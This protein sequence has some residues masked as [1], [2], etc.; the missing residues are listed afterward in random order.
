MGTII[1]A[2]PL[3]YDAVTPSE[4]Q[5]IT[6]RVTIEADEL[7]QRLVSQGGSFCATRD[8]GGLSTNIGSVKMK[9]GLQEGRERMCLGRPDVRTVWA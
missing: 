7:V 1:G 5:V 3:H 4:L 9:C 2:S 8:L 6:G